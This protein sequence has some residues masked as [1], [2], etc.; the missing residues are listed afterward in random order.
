MKILYAGN[1][2]NVGYMISRQLRKDGINVDLL[3]PKN[4]SPTSDPLIFDPSLN[5][6]YPEWIIFY[7]KKKRSW[8]QDIIRIMRNKKYDLIHAHVELPIFAY[9]AR[10][11]FIAHVLGSDI[12]ELSF[13]NSLKGWLLRRAYKRAKAIFFYEPLDPS[14]LNK[15]KLKTGIHMPVMWDTSFFKPTTI[16]KNELEGKFSIIHPANLDWR[17]KGND[18]LIKGFA[19]FVKN[20]S[21]S[22]LLIVDR[23]IDSEKTKNLV[24]SLKINDYVQYIKGPLSY[25]DLLNYYNKVDV[26]ADQFFLDGIGSIG[27]ETFSCEKPLLTYCTEETYGDLYPEPP[28]AVNAHTPEE[29]L[30]QLELLQNK[31]FRNKVG[32]KGREWITKYRSPELISKKIIQVYEMVLKGEKIEKIREAVT[33]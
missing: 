32:K 24:N 15:L 10:R 18:I 30:K 28:P 29:I 22:I 16:E 26:V 9:I 14:L 5:G 21:N 25:S 11:P 7:D 31:E 13:E 12:R 23:G 6:N 17:L 2:A 19:K 8:K 3:I 33:N 27:A 4:P 1:M 20:Y